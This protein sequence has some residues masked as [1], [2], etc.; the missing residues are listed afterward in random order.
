MKRILYLLIIL[1]FARCSK[2][3]GGKLVCNMTYNLSNEKKAT[4]A[5]KSY[6]KSDRYSHF[7]DYITSVTPDKFLIKFLHLRLCDTWENQNNHLDIIDNNKL[8]WTSTDRI[9]DFSEN[10][11]VNITIEGN[12]T[13][14]IEMI[15]LVSIPMFYYQE[16]ELPEQYTDFT[17]NMQGSNNLACLSFGGSVNVD[18]RAATDGIGGTKVG[19][20]VKGG[21]NPLM[22]PIFDENWIDVILNGFPGNFPKWPRTIVFGNTNTT[23]I[24][25]STG[26]SIN[27]PMGNGGEII[28]SDKF[29]PITLSAIPEGE[30]KAITGIMT[31]N[32]TGLI[33]IYAGKDNVPFTYDDVFVYAPNYWERISVSLNYY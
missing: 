14:N 19:R 17:I 27:D 5:G 12:V 28:R 7:G 1:C 3:Q 10:G 8:E 26:T 15:Y 30:T 9:A 21:N 33:Q 16:F 24:Y 22:A 31:F 6:L 18:Y 13:A 32:T 29:N 23:Y 20:T 2:E 25:S 4:S 11:T